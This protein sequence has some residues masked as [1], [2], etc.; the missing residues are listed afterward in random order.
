MVDLG[1]RRILKIKQSNLCRIMVNVA[2]F[3]HA[4]LLAP[5]VSSLPDN[6]SIIEKSSIS[7]LCKRNANLTRG[8]T[9][10]VDIK[11]YG[12]V[13]PLKMVLNFVRLSSLRMSSIRL[14]E[15]FSSMHLKEPE[16][17]FRTANLRFPK[18]IL[19]F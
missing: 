11:L 9:S 2:E 5:D 13:I 17:E 7:G 1:G 14:R 16:K 3:L 8:I 15:H 19:T 18:T 12:R 10:S 4:L 6:P